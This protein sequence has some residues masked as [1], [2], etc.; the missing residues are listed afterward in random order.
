MMKFAAVF[1]T[2]V[3]ATEHAEHYAALNK[4]LEGPAEVLNSPALAE[5]HTHVALANP[6][7]TIYDTCNQMRVQIRTDRTAATKKEL[8]DRKLCRNTLSA[9][10]SNIDKNQKNKADKIAEAARLYKAHSALWDEPNSLNKTRAARNVSIASQEVVVK[11]G[12]KARDDAH[13][14]FL[15]LQAAFET[16]LEQIGVIHRVLNGEGTLS[17]LGGG[18]KGFL[19]EQSCSARFHQ[20]VKDTKDVPRVSNMLQVF[21]ES[22]EKVEN[23]KDSTVAG[24]VRGAKVSTKT[25]ARENKGNM[26]AVNALLKK[27]RENLVK[28]MQLSY[29]QE[30]TLINL[31]K[32]KKQKLR[33][34]INDDWILNWK[35][36]VKQ[37]QVELTI[38]QDWVKEGNAKIRAAQYRK[39]ADETTIMNEFLSKRCAKSRRDYAAV[40]SNYANELNALDRVI[41]YLKENVFP[42]W[43]KDIVDTVSSPYSW[44]IEKAHYI[45]VSNTYSSV[46]YYKDPVSCRKGYATV[47]TGLRL[48]TQTRTNQKFIDPNDLTKS[49]NMQFSR[50]SKLKGDVECQTFPS[51]IPVGTASS[52]S[53]SK[54]AHAS[55][56]LT[57]TGYKFGKAA[58]RM[59]VTL[60]RKSGKSKVKFTDGGRKVEISTVGRCGQTYPDDN[61]LSADYRA[62]PIPLEK[63]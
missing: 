34:K 9:Y 13:A 52:C 58:Q 28:S 47:F 48:L 59:F 5:L 53:T 42:K 49:V 10:E 45:T 55:I 1:V 30:T 16:A 15:K 3:L 39:R 17:D 61:G 62:D 7:K 56:D 27:V 24:K 18:D 21:A 6:M 4:M 57:G 43:S 41:R 35:N 38:G 2:A 31:W 26:D 44:K 36:F 51:G 14:E 50:K 22:F 8:I 32:A 20:L 25:N 29:K 37:G 63:A 33:R 19:E 60:G 54:F 46:G 40:M 12:Q 23:A 11:R